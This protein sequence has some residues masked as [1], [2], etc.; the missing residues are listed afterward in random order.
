V[1]QCVLFEVPHSRL[2]LVLDRSKHLLCFA[3]HVTN[4]VGPKIV[5]EQ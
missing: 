2:S 5:P 1:R 4:V 3:S